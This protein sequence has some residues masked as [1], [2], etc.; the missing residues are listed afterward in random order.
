M[1][2][3]LYVSTIYVLYLSSFLINFILPL[4]LEAIGYAPL[5]IGFLIGVLGIVRVPLSPIAGLIADI[6]GRRSMLVLGSIL[7]SLGI[8]LLLLKDFSVLIL[9]RVLVG[10]SGFF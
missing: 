3:F 5:F 7:S 8:M 1:E 9:G 4:Y 10:F 2:L 6:I